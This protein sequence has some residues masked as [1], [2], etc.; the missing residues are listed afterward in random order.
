MRGLTIVFDL[1]GTLVDTAPDLVAAT[2]HALGLEGLLPVPAAALTSWVS[3]GARR[4]L[5]EGLRHTAVT[6]TEADVDRLLTRFLA[7]YEANIAVK[8]RPFDGAVPVLLEIKQ[9]GAKL[10]VCTNK[11]EK[12]SKL[13][14]RELDIAQLFD[15]VAGRDTFPVS[16]P[17]PDHLLGAIRLAG[18]N[19]GRSVMVGDTAVDIET[20]RAAGIPSIAVGFGYSDVPAAQLGAAATIFHY[21]ELGAAVA[22]LHPQ[23]GGKVT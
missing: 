20:A 9:T 18:G 10:A 1:D 15:A 23:Y 5:V 14:L 4:M 2:N 17:H 22:A 13:L 19:P 7:Y 12:L 6:R 8:S 11:R 16:K 21:R 3:H